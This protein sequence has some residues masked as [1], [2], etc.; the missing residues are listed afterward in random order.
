MIK[1]SYVAD[2][3][4]HFKTFRKFDVPT[5]PLPGLYILALLAKTILF[6]ETP[7][8]KIIKFYPNQIAL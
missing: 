5:E 6:E 7:I 4:F 8:I 2:D 1:N 3:L